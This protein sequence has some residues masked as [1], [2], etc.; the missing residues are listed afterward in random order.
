[1]ILGLHTITLVDGINPFS[2]LEKPS[3]PSKDSQYGMERMESNPVSYLDI[4]PVLAI[5]VVLAAIL[6]EHLDDHALFVVALGVSL[7]PLGLAFRCQ[8]WVNPQPEKYHP[9]GGECHL[10]T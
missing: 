8:Q 3:D 4:A 7:G 6:A 2:H 10:F 9:I 1:M 5:E